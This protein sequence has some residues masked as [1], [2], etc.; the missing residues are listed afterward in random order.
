MTQTQLAVLFGQ[1]KAALVPLIEKATTPQPRTDFLTRNYP[2]HAQKDFARRS[3][4][5]W[6]MI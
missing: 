3:R 5:R 1:L 2:S 6:A 4:P